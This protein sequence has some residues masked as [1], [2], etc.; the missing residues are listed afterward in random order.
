LTVEH[1]R[2]DPGS[3]LSL[4]REA[5]R[6]RRELPSLGDGALKWL[7]APSDVLAFSREPGFLCVVNTGATAVAPPT[8]G[9]VLLASQPLCSDG[10]LPGATAVWYAA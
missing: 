5:L 9:Q 10:R 4:Y 8:H 7:S 3:M 2:A 6:L 1:Q